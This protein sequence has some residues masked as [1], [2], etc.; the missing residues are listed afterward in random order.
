MDFMPSRSVD[1]DLKEMIL[2]PIGKLWEMK[3]A[4]L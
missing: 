1:K 3:A 4:L 2:R